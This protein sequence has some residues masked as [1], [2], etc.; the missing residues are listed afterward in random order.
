MTEK[1]K[2]CDKNHIRGYQGEKLLKFHLQIRQSCKTKVV[3]SIRFNNKNAKIVQK[4]LK[5]GGEPDP[6]SLDLQNFN[7]LKIVSIFL[8]LGA[9]TVVAYTLYSQNLTG[10]RMAQLDP[11]LGQQEKS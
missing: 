4:S 1:I 2:F 8:I 11:K 7:F 9:S 5:N 6:E 3:A 10:Y